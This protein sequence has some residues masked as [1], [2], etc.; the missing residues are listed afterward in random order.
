[1]VLFHNEHL[2]I[3]VL[4]SLTRLLGLNRS[5]REQKGDIAS[6]E[7]ASRFHNSQYLLLIQA[8]EARNSENTPAVEQLQ[9]IIN[10]LE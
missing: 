4:L 9:N 1:V 8:G 10:F 6:Y 2:K 7:N 5:L 3:S